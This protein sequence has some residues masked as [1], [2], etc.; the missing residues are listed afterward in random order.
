VQ[1][2]LDARHDVL[3]LR[4]DHTMP[5]ANSRKRKEKKKRAVPDQRGLRR[6]R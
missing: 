4:H 3:E 6:G 1:R 5:G 2:V